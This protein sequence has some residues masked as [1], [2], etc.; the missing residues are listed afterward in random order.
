MEARSFVRSRARESRGK[1]SR[2]YI[3]QRASHDRS[4]IS[5]SLSL[6]T[7]IQYVCIYRCAPPTLSLSPVTV[8]A[9][10]GSHLPASMYSSSSPLHSLI[11]SDLLWRR[12]MWL[13]IKAAVLQVTY[14]HGESRRRYICI[15]KNIALFCNFNMRFVMFVCFCFRR[16]R[17]IYHFFCLPLMYTRGK[18]KLVEKKKRLM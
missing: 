14:T 11:L 1:V 7:Y 15:R 6:Y 8:E 16:N 12:V 2:L 4:Y 10:L 17:T 18:K 9:P 5:F 3:H 13:L